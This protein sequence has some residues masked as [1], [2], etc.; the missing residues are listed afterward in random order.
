VDGPGLPDL[1][2]RARNGSRE[3]FDGLLWR[4]EI[5]VRA[6]V[7][8][9]GRGIFRAEV[10]VEDALQEVWLRAWTSLAK[11][12]HRGPGSFFAWVTGIAR[13]VIHDYEKRAAYRDTSPIDQA[14]GSADGDIPPLVDPQTT[15]ASR[16]ASGERHAQVRAALTLIAPESREIVEKRFFENLSLRAI[17]E[18]MSI[19][20]EV[21]T[22]R[23]RQ[24]LEQLRDRVPNSRST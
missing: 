1:I 9:L 19:P 4:N 7:K 10:D 2:T 17:S 12:E 16:V 8:R 11:Y 5:P 22:R 18:Q 3:A 21:V 6:F 24:G 13:N 23:F 15:A 14:G 20:R